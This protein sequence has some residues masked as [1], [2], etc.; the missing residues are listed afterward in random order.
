MGVMRKYFSYLK[1]FLGTVINKFGAK[2]AAGVIL[3]LLY[4]YLLS[5]RKPTLYYL[6]SRRNRAI[7][8]RIKGLKNYRPPPL[9]RNGHLMTSWLG[10]E[11]GLVDFLG[12]APFPALKNV[13]RQFLQ[14]EGNKE[15]PWP[16]VV[17]LNW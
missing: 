1:R 5:G 6:K 10:L 16:G 7:V 13:K 4:R 2:G 17:T 8:R 14:C 3:F 15:G 9:V 11:M 12:V